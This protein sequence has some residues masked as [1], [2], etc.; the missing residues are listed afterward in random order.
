MP[1]IDLNPEFDATLERLRTEFVNC[2]KID[3]FLIN[4]Q[5]LLQL[6]TRKLQ[7]QLDRIPE[8]ANKQVQE[9]NINAS[10]EVINL[11]GVLNRSSNLELKEKVM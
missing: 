8:L 1:Y 6:F 7:M 4:H 9:I 3:N 2:N 11:L 5:K 10:P